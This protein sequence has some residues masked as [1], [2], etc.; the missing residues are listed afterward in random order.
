MQ[1]AARW[2][3]VVTAASLPLSTA[4]TN[5]FA[6]LAFLCWALSGQWTPALRAVAAEPVAWLG[7]ALFAALALGIAWS[8][9]PPQEA[10]SVLLKYREL[11]LF[12]VALFLF[13]DARWRERLLGAFFVGAL[14]LLIL[15]YAVWLGLLHFVD[16][17]G[18]SSTENA[19]LLKNAITHGLLMSLLAY[20]AAVYALRSAGARRWAFA[21]VAALAAVNVWFAVQGR[22]GYVVMAVL[23]LWLAY[24]RWSVKGFVAAALGLSV[25]LGAAY[26]GVPAFQAR[27]N[28]AAEEARDYRQMKHPGETSIGSRL[29]FW[30]RSAEWMTKHPLLG[31]GTGG[32]A[33]AFYEATAGDDAFMHNRDRDHPHNEYVHLAVQLG[34]LGLALY[35]AL[36]WAAYR[37]AG[38]LPDGYAVLAQGFVLAFAVASLFNDVLRDSTEGHLWAL[39]GGALF[40]ASRALRGRA[41]T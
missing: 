19:V 34:P 21:L 1:N 9:V 5:L 38:L 12:G 35:L 41:L 4:A 28:E 11:L 20:G 18:F 22:T 31:A 40:G 6:A 24:T 17:R 37:R 15:S 7:C 13:A 26:Q 33:E 16:A 27:I 3:F 25:L 2:C 14:V 30:K 29:H 23:F 39:V 10:A 32:W 36:L 8:R